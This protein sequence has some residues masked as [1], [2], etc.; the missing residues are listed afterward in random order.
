M[1]KAILIVGKENEKF[2][3]NHKRDHKGLRNYRY[4]KIIHSLSDIIDDHYT[5]YLFRYGFVKDVFVFD[6]CELDDLSLS[7]NE[8]E[9]FVKLNPSD[10][11]RIGYKWVY[12]GINCRA[13]YTNDADIDF[14]CIEPLLKLTI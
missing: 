4:F 3:F 6:D 10:Q 11:K 2:G 8:D 1:G 14:D 7:N 13:F 12:R 5:V 9:M